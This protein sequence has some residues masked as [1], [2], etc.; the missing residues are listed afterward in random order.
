MS[1]KKQLVELKEEFVP[2]YVARSEFLNMNMLILCLVFSS[3]VKVQRE[4]GLPVLAAILPQAGASQFKTERR[5]ESK[6]GSQKCYYCTHATNQL[7][8]I[9]GS[10]RKDFI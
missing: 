10:C 6:V 7:K 3:F 2:A 4:D 5:E 9:T 1:L 8:I